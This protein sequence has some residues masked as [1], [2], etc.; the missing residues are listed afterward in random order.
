[1]KKSVKLQTSNYITSSVCSYMQ[2]LAIDELAG[3]D[4]CISDG[5]REREREREREYG[6]QFHQWGSQ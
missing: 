2:N 5:E 1:M 3:T 6:L 4:T